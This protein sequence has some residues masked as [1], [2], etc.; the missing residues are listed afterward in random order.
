MPSGITPKYVYDLVTVGDPSLSPDGTRVAYTRSKTE[1][2]TSEDSSIIVMRDI[3]SGASSPFTGGPKDSHPIF[4]PD[5]DFLA[6][7]RP[8]ENGK[9]QLWLIPTSGGEARKLTSVEGGVSQPTWSSDSRRIAFV[10]DV[11]P[12]DGAEDGVP[13]VRVVR[14]IRYRADTIGWRGDA[15]RHIFIAEI[16][17]G[18][19]RQLTEGEGEDSSP[20]W[21]PDGTQ[22]AFISDR[23]A[24]R[25]VV[26][27][28]ALY[29]IPSQGGEPR[30]VSE[31]LYSVAA[32]AWSPDGSRLAVI[33]SDDEQVGAGWQGRLFVLQNG[34]APE[35]ITDD[36]VRPA[37]GY[38]PI[39]PPPDLRWTIDDSIL[40]L[41]DSKGESYLC[42]VSASG[43]EISRIAGGGGAQFGTLSLNE[44]SAYGVVTSATPKSTANIALIDLRGGSIR[45]LTDYNR[46]YFDEHPPA[47]LEKL[48]LTRDGFEI[49][50]R[51]YFPP[52]FVE[53]KNYPMVLDIHGGPHG[54]FFDAFNPT[55]QVL[56]SHGYVVL[57]VNPRGS[58][59]YGIEFV[60]AV[61]GDWGDGD[62]EDI[63]AAVD[64][65]CKR[66]Y[67]DASRLGITGYSYGGYMSSWIVGHDTRFNAA[68]VGAPVSNISSFY[69][70]SDIGVRFLERQSD[71]MLMA[72]PDR[73]VE[74]SPLTYVSNVQTPVLLLH[75]E[76]DLRC[77]IEQSEQYFV[78]LKRL[79]KEV[80]F[81]RFP[82][83]SHMFMR[84]GHPK[85]R[86][87]YFARMLAWFDAR[88]GSGAAQ[89]RRA[90]AV[91]ADD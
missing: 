89:A 91:S 54:A 31:G 68:V 8:D 61:L 21:S 81:V 45:L 73:Y 18:S 24:E 22:I 76:A 33:G 9:G 38:A 69:G 5:G 78:A 84:F 85:M 60:K 90:E 11:I 35:A 1:R 10:S 14:R 65:V 47:G 27:G 29:V 15:F 64:E 26:D 48:S 87:E 16:N 4:S 40:F 62:Y 74:Q 23:G 37:A 46:E 39:I 43:G 71:G 49:E 70:T 58:S 55:Q 3:E 67:I 19:I 56:A 32:V 2:E 53:A 72:E 17:S 82:D 75:G 13:Q 88:I 79:G 30:L 51:L 25:D 28:D 42:S 44:S 83:C 36:S 12:D 52:D 20:A 63:M 7:L 66:P 41:A 34:M 6:F 77:P 50:F 86:E 57:A 80:E 59:T